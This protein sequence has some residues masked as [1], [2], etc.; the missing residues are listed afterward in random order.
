M[1]RR[2]PLMYFDQGRARRQKVRNVVTMRIE[3]DESIILVHEVDPARPSMWNRST[4]ILPTARASTAPSLTPTS[5]CCWMRCSATARSLT[6][7]YE[8]E[9]AWDR[10]TNVLEGWTIQ[11]EIQRKRHKTLALPQYP[12]GTGPGESDGS[13]AQA[14]HHWRNVT[15]DG[16]HEEA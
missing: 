15:P 6:A 11:E 1:F 7:A 10:V 14:G 9:L 4:W 3:R 2:P 13:L 8:T 5:D 12:A 16:K